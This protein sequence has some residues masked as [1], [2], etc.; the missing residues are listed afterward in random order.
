MEQPIVSAYGRL[1][2][3][4]AKCAV[5]NT[6]TAAAHGNRIECE[7][8]VSLNVICLVVNDSGSR[9]IESPPDLRAITGPA[10]CLAGIL[11]RIREQR[12]DDRRESIQEP[13]P[14]FRISAP[15]EIYLEC[16]GL[17]HHLNARWPDRVEV[18]RHARITIAM[19]LERHCL[20]VVE[21]VDSPRQQLDSNV[22]HCLA[23]NF[24][25]TLRRVDDL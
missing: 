12:D 18:T 16:R 20:N 7:A 13:P 21:R 9:R 14:G 6:I 19:E 17:P 22:R 3:P 4:G 1:G 8:Q 5:G 10:R 11:A 2:H 15:L 25:E 23:K 24:H